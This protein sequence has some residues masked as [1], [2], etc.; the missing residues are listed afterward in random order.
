MPIPPHNKA[1]KGKLQGSEQRHGWRLGAGA[2]CDPT[3]FSRELQRYDH[4]LSLIIGKELIFSVT[5]SPVTTR[6]L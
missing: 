3:A 2:E 6:D 5:G 1:S 4:A